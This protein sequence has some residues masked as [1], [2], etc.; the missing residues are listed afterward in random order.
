MPQKDE[1]GRHELLDRSAIIMEMVANHLLEHKG[2][3]KDEKKLAKAA[4]QTLFELYQ[5]LGERT[6][7]SEDGGADNDDEGTRH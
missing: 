3:K 1:F 6:L 7:G 2:L 5:L 4:H